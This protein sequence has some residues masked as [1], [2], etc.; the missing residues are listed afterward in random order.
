[1]DNEDNVRAS[2]LFRVGPC[3]VLAWQDKSGAT[4]RRL[5][6]NKW[7]L[8]LALRGL[9]EPNR[10]HAWTPN[11]ERLDVRELLKKGQAEFRARSGRGFKNMMG[12]RKWLG[13]LST[14]AGHQ[15][16]WGPV[17]N[18]H[19][20]S[21]GRCH[22]RMHTQHEITWAQSVDVNEPAPRAKRSPGVLPTA[23]DDESMQR[24]K[25]WKAQGK[26][27][28]AWARKGRA[29]TSDRR[30]LARLGVKDEDEEDNEYAEDSAQSR[31]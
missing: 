9:R 19:K 10:A 26:G 14:C 24:A 11:G 23:W 12:A 6:V 5:F 25:G 8:E 7:D 13:A 16:R 21:G 28:K 17:P 4:S 1:M 22:R 18:I 31:S 29:A 15:T 20:S 2:V 30:A 27:A 3:Y